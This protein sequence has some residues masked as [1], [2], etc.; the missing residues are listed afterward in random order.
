MEKKRPLPDPTPPERGRHIELTVV[1]T[2]PPSRSAAR[3]GW[4]RLVPLALRA[5][6]LGIVVA[7][8]WL[9]HHHH[10]RLRIDGDAPIR[11][12]EVLPFFPGAARLRADESDRAGLFVLGADG[13]SVGYVLRTAPMS[14]TITGYCGPTDTLVALGPDQRVIGIRIRSSFDT[15]EHV[16]D[17][18]NDAYF[19][20]TWTGKTW[21]EVA[22]MEPHA[23]GIEG[24]SGA[25]LTSLAIANGIRQ[26]FHRA[27][28]QAAAPPPPVHF[29]PNDIGL[30]TVIGVSLL[31]T[32]THLRGRPWLRRAF[33]FVLIGYVGLMNGQLLAQSLWA[34]WAASTVPWRTAPGLAL[35]AAAALIVPW[36]TRRAMY[37]SHLCPHGAAQEWLGRVSRQKVRL[38]S[39]IEAGLRWLPYLLIATVLF[40]TIIHFEF[41]LAGIEPFD[42]YLLRSAGVATTVIALVG[43]AA[44]GAVPMAYCKYGCPTG[45]VLSFVRSHGRAD[46]FGRRDV[47]AAALVALAAGLYAGYEPI[48]HWAVR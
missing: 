41:N 3:G 10:A 22:G 26:R 24:T 1:P 14:N 9:I 34:G 36:S 29:G 23:A 27:T 40:V 25:S 6:R 2:T 19:M 42:A 5:Y 31:F 13:A 18:A 32:F 44:S 21:D 4:G 16:Q 37:C 11:V 20:K 38:P 8:V 39:G 48:R 30:V 28:T 35:L 45:M 12:A 46:H 15:K 47:A 43:L 7:I 33:Q 17:V